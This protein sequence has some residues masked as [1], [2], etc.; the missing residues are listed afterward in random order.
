MAVH[1][2]FSSCNTNTAVLGEDD[3]KN[4]DISLLKKYRVG[5]KI[6]DAAKEV[7]S[8]RSDADGKTTT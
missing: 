7:L 5:T 1:I 8:F 4:G 3:F 2:K 6:T